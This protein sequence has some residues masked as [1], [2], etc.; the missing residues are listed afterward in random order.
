MTSKSTKFAAVVAAAAL[1]A[2]GMA[3]GAS[4][5]TAPSVIKIGTLYAGSGQ[6]A[7]SSQAQ[8]KGLQ[9]WAKRVNAQGGVFVKAYGKKIPVKIVAYDDQSSTSTATTLYNQLITQDKVDLVVADF[10]SVLTSVAI[11]LAK[12][13]HKMLVDVTGSSAGFFKGKENPYIADIS[14]PSS[15]V[16]PIPLAK[17]LIHEHVKKVAILYGSNDFDGSQAD[18]LKAQL[19]AA[20]ITP[21]F[22]HAVPTNETN[23]TVLLHSAAARQP[24]AMVEL[25]YMT[26]DVAFLKSLKSS[27]LHFPFV[28]TIFPGQFKSLMEK[29][30]GK[31]ALKYTYSYPAPP[32]VKYEKV[33]LGMGTTPFVKAWGKAHNGAEANFVNAAGYNAGLIMGKMLGDAPKFDQKA[34]HAALEGMSG[35][36]DTVIGHFKMGQD[37]AQLGQRLP[38]AQFQ[39]QKDGSLKTVVVYPDAVKTGDAIYPS[40]AG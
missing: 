13:H 17:F 7:V 11:P 1:A 8:Y 27:G 6:F 38:V 28:F 26:N 15:G 2:A 30:A 36:V 21:V 12:E 20:G 14:I 32:M 5:A 24:Q 23:Y 10:G 39:P 33:N 37:G 29:N 40:P 34:F 19:K 9:F 4:A 25:G 3:G 35:K 18:T 31:D 16:W 22:D